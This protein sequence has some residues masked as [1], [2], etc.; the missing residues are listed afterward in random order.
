MDFS[1]EKGQFNIAMNEIM[2]GIDKKWGRDTKHDVT[3]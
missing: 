2:T 1:L 3:E